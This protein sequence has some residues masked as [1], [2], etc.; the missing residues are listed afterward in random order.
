[1]QLSLISI[2]LSLLY[3]GFIGFAVAAPYIPDV[4][5]N[6]LHPEV[7]YNSTTPNEDEYDDHCKTRSASCYPGVH[8]PHLNVDCHEHGAMMPSRQLRDF[9]E[10]MKV[11]APGQTHGLA[12]QR[13]TLLTRT[14]GGLVKLC[15]FNKDAHKD[16][17]ITNLEAGKALWSVENKCCWEE[18]GLYCRGG[19]WFGESVDGLE[20]E[21]VAI[22]VGED[23]RDLKDAYRFEDTPEN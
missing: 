13:T 2:V 18:N 14:T 23:C 7:H 15:V 10:E 9:A 4:P 8:G 6:F 19:R 21:L 16:T 22:N 1:M 17:A 20:I 11:V 3:L 12:H 5:D